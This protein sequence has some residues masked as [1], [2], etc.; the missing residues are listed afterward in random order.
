[1]V[2]ACETKPRLVVGGEVDGHP[3]QGEEREH[4]LVLVEGGVKAVLPH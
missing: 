1:M 2:G 4:I 3:F